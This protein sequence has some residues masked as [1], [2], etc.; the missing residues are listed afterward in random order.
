VVSEG[1][2]E[3]QFF[4]VLA[5]FFNPLPQLFQ[6]GLALLVFVARRHDIAIHFLDAHLR[7][8]DEV[9]LLVN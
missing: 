2:T 4:K 7:A 8:R 1:N 3:L 9:C 5:G 6:E